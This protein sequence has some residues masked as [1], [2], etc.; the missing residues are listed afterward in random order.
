[1]TDCADAQPDQGLH[2]LLTDSLDTA[3]CMNRDQRPEDCI[4]GNWKMSQR[5]HNVD[6]TFLRRRLPV[7]MNPY[8]LRMFKGT[9]GFSLTPVS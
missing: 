5:A 6:A 1:M 2:C 4:Q 9:R 3:K 7:G 8:I